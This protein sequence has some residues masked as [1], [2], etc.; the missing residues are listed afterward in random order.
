MTF[1]ETTKLVEA[2]NSIET[3][4]TAIIREKDKDNPDRKELEKFQKYLEQD[5]QIV[6]DIAN[7]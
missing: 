2:L 6:F 7:K 5:R 3:W 4:V 1:A